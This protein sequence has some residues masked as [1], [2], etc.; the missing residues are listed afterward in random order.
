MK[1]LKVQEQRGKLLLF[2]I[3]LLINILGLHGAQY[4]YISIN[5]TANYSTFMN[6]N[7]PL[8]LIDILYVVVK[9]YQLYDG[10]PNLR[11]T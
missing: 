5:T 4:K 6:K 11:S 1:L 2:I 8:Q 7:K 10:T 9:S 3:V